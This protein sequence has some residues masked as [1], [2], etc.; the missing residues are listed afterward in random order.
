[1]KQFVSGNDL[2][3]SLELNE[4]L[5]RDDD[6]RFFTVFIFAVVF[7]LAG[8]TFGAMLA[9]AE[10]PQTTRDQI[11]RLL[12]RLR[13]PVQ[14]IMSEAGTPS[15]KTSI[16]T[17]DTLLQLGN[18]GTQQVNCEDVAFIASLSDLGKPALNQIVAA[19]GTWPFV[20]IFR[21]SEK[22][23]VGVEFDMTL[24]SGDMDARL[25][26]GFDL[27][28]D[29]VKALKK[30]LTIASERYEIARKTRGSAMT[31]VFPAAGVLMAQSKDTP[32]DKWLHLV[33]A[34]T[35]DRML[36]KRG[37]E[38]FSTSN[39]WHRELS[40]KIDGLEMAISP[41]I[42][43][44]KFKHC[45]EVVF[46]YVYDLPSGVDINKLN[47]WNQR[48]WYVKAYPLDEKMVMLEMDLAVFDGISEVDFDHYINSWQGG[49]SSFQ[50][51]ITDE[52][53]KTEKPGV[54]SPSMTNNDTDQSEIATCFVKH[55]NDGNPE[56]TCEPIAIRIITDCLK[57]ADE[58]V[59]K[60]KGSY[61]CIG[62]VANPCID[63]AWGVNES[64][65]VTC[66]MTEEKIWLDIVKN[67]LEQMKTRLP[68]A[69]KQHLI[70]MERAFLTYRRE[71]CGI[72]R[73]LQESDE[74]NLAYSACTTETT[75]RFAIDLRDMAPYT[76][77][78]DAE[79]DKKRYSGN[80]QGAEKRP[81]RSANPSDTG[82]LGSKSAPVHAHRPSGQH[83]YLKRLRCSDGK[84]PSF[85]RRGSFQ[86]GGYGNLIDLYN[87]RC[88]NNKD[89]YEIYM[90]MYH[91]GH[92]EMRPVPGFTLV[93]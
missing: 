51:F 1:M 68:K 19:N 21:D 80:R 82:V 11:A 36:K 91:P 25:S 39:L 81:D 90:D 20:R 89:N 16:H 54:D 62:L 74:S 57:K 75:A 83:A 85:R 37:I 47:E 40:I 31:A 8:M 28:G 76:N 23:E 35:L 14:Y 41:A 70:A 60:R 87:V 45:G 63:S 33:T 18:C 93:Q 77:K 66:V 88:D 29:I 27:W 53:T 13:F 32:A 34:D 72:V 38:T 55:S 2:T 52:E 22:G 84:A 69:Q 59:D 71:H 49:I 44:K 79:L 17:V 7:A 61:H 3:K 10:E 67:N 92:I 5:L 43:N 9:R 42:C 30:G 24:I 56:K 4:M 15:I 26:A 65:Y 46:S 12:E 50:S 58:D 64:R 73:S 48:E 6:R 86:I 78:T